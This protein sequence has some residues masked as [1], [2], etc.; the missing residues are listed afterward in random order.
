MAKSR[1]KKRKASTDDSVGSTLPFRGG[2][3]DGQYRLL[4]HSVAF[5]RNL[6]HHGNVVW[7]ETYLFGVDARGDPCYYFRD[8]YPVLQM[9]W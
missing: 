4:G 1:K 3:L 5:Y 6:D 9:I 2:A 8:R 7:M